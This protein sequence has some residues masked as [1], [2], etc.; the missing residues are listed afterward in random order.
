MKDTMCGLVKEENGPS[1][2]VYHTDLPV[3]QIDDDEVLIKVHCTA[4]CGTDLHIMEWDE[5]SQKRI[6]APVTVGHET[7][8]EIVAG[9]KN[10]TERKVGDRVSC[11]SHI[12]C[13]ECYF[14]KNGMPH[15]CKNV[16]L[17]GCTQNGAFAE[18]AKIRWDCTFLLEDDVTD[19][20]ACMF[21]P[22]GAG[23]HGVEA[24]EVNGK[25]VLVSGCGPIGLTAISASKTFGAVKVI[26][27]DLIDE[28]LEE[29]MKEVLEIVVMGRACRNTANIK[30]RQPIGTMFVKADKQLSDFYQEIIEDELNVKKVVFTDDVRDFTAYTFKPQL[31]TVGPKYGKQLGGIKKHLDELD[32]N[33]AMDELESVGALKFDVNGTEVELTKED[34]LIDMAQKPGYVSEAD[35]YMTVVLDTNLSEELLEEGFVYEVISK[36]QTM[37]KDA[38]FEVMDHIKVSVCGNEKVEGIVARNE[39][40][41][42]GKVLADAFVGE[43]ALAVSKEWNVNGETVTIGVEKVNA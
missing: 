10:V 38:G 2:L 31:R 17:F 9:G 20:A 22:M 24:A 23:I 12:P 7:A 11:E 3:P 25:T 19:E 27:C 34:L 16:K 26:A 6:K 8:G 1:G 40:M 4:I 29:D 36:I 21:E 42:A 18:Y 32:G 30:N 13:G 28:K 5:W 14:C 41:I 15:I 35:N 43:E 33:A 37:R 39:A